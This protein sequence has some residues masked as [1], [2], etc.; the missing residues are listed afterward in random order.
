MN[1]VIIFSA[2]TGQGHN[3]VAEALKVE[4]EN[5]GSNVI[6]IEPLKE[7]SKALNI[8]VSDGYKILATK[9]PKM[10]G[11]MYKLSNDEVINKSVTKV[12]ISTVKDKIKEILFNEAPD[13]VISTHAFIVKVMCSIKQEAK[14]DTPFISVVTDYLPHE[15]YISDLVDAYIVGSTY[16]KMGIVEKGINPNKVYV[17]GIP[18]KRRFLEQNEAQR[19]DS[20]FTILLM[21]GSMGVTSIKKAL[22]NLITV[23]EDLKIIVV[24]GN[25]DQLKKSLQDK[26][27]D[28]KYNKS[29]EILG[30]TNN[31]PELMDLSDVIITKPGGLTVT[32]ALVKN[33][34][35]IIPYFIPGQE[36]E[37]AKVLVDAGA[38]LKVDSIKEL[39]DVVEKLMNEP[40]AIISLKDNM[41]KISKYYSLDDAIELCFELMAVYKNNLNMEIRDAR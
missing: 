16:T 39:D 18:I 3:Q 8:L 14:V 25:N 21:G 27:S 6:I 4:L 36:E 1:K 7:A 20:I 5:K 2:S 24:C 15:S 12:F 23:K 10:Y 9:M 34:P 33:I 19:K 41:N 13:L 40:D 37:N 30:Y 28:C 26:Y 22:K 29:I 35:M 11:K 31:I 17:Y 32:E 38:A